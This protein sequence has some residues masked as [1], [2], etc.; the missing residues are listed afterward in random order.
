MSN[1][2]EKLVDMFETVN[3]LNGWYPLPKTYLTKQ[4]GPWFA[5]NRA[6]SKLLYQPTHLDR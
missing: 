6:Y 2:V 5:T 3:V 1:L 4:S